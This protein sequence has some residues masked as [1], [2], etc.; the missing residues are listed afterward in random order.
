MVPSLSPCRSSADPKNKVD[1]FLGVRFAGLLKGFERQHSILP[2]PPPR[3]L[4]SGSFLGWQ[5]H[6]VPGSLQSWKWGCSGLFRGPWSSASGQAAGRV[7]FGA[8]G[9]GPRCFQP[10]AEGAPSSRAARWIRASFSCCVGYSLCAVYFLGLS[11]TPRLPPKATRSC[12]VCAR[13]ATLVQAW[14][15]VVGCWCK[16]AF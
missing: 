9:R 5:R 13:S 8:S 16:Y 15:A 14:L 11:L 3:M 7:V 6:F 1:S 2:D 4:V 10:L 12:N